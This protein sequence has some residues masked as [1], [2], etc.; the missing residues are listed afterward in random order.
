MAA[1]A[2]VAAA[3]LVGGGVARAEV[4]QLRGRIVGHVGPHGPATRVARGIPGSRAARKA[5]V[6]CGSSRAGTT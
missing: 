2:G 5:A 1:A 6:G 4:H 3:L